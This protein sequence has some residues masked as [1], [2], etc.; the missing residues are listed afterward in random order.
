MCNAKHLFIIVSAF[1]RL[2][3][4][5]NVLE[6]PF[7]FF[8]FPFLSVLLGGQTKVM[9]IFFCDYCFKGLLQAS[10]FLRLLLWWRGLARLHD[11]LKLLYLHSHSA[12]NYETWQDGNLPR[13][14]LTHKVTWLFGHVAL[15]NHVTNKNHFIS[16]AL[17]HMTTKLGRMTTFFE[18][19]P[20]VKLFDSLVTWLCRTRWN[21]KSIISS[22][23]QCQWQL[24]LA[25]NWLS[26]NSSPYKN[27]WVLWSSSLARLR[28]KL[29]SLYLPYQSP[30]GH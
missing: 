8:F 19:L 20:H 4:M 28:D 15:Q 12:Y 10:V 16:T 22:P 1:S 21:S 30:H 27:T 24:N 9:F 26:L 25:G 2:P 7:Y 11:K 3:V 13:W 23:S 6:L 5:Q 17:V 18:W 29:K 14:A